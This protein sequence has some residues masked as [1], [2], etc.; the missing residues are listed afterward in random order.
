MIGLLADHLSNLRGG[1]GHTTSVA[2]SHPGVWEWA[3]RLLDPQPAPHNIEKLCH[4]LKNLEA[5]S[6]VTL[7]I[8]VC[9]NPHKT[10]AFKEQANS[11]GVK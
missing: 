7:L 3:E 11:Y 2:T 1:S 10:L 8:S 4:D 6:I 5:I 9:Y